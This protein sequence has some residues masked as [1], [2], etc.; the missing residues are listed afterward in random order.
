MKFEGATSFQAY[1][2]TQVHQCTKLQFRLDEHSYNI[3]AS[4]ISTLNAE[5]VSRCRFALRMAARCQE[6]PKE[7]KL[8]ED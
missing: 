7:N 8:K 6:A 1:C 4:K 2:F 3:K 5:K